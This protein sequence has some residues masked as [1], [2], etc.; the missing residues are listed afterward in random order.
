MMNFRFKERAC[1]CRSNTTC[2]TFWEFATLCLAH[3][4]CLC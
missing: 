3:R 4:K 1:I 2:T